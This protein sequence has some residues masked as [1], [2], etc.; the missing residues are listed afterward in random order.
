MLLWSRIYNIVPIFYVTISGDTVDIEGWNNAIGKQDLKRSGHILRAD[1]NPEA[2]IMVTRGEHTM[3]A[4]KPI[5]EI[6]VCKL[7]QNSGLQI[8]LFGSSI[9]NVVAYFKGGLRSK[10]IILW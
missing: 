6:K 2:N 7:Q 3:S 1:W 9:Y 10:R 4:W 5:S 8:M